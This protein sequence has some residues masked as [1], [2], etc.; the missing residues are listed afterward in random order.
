MAQQLDNSL[1][2]F[3]P[4]QIRPGALLIS[5]GTGV[6]L[7][8]GMALSLAS[9]AMV[10]AAII[11]ASLIGLAALAYVSNRENRRLR[12]HQAAS[13][14]EW[15]SAS[16]E[17]QRQ[18]LNV[19][20]GELSRALKSE[21]NSISDLRTAFI[22]A[23]DLALRQIEQEECVPLK[24]NVVAGGVPFDAA[25]VKDNVLICGEFSFLVSPEL[26]Q[27]RVVAMMK[28]IAAVNRSL[29][30]M[31][32]GVRARLMVVIVTQMPD[33][34]MAA[35]RESLSTA[36]FSSTPTDIDIRLLDFDSLQRTYISE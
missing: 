17:L 30:V 18:N 11:G 14:I 20:V 10:I 3:A 23:E 26:P 29:Q 36:R 25:F 35:L 27:E 19:A 8:A 15:G 16:P 6:L 32:V 2:R 1:D 28:K 21:P 5:G 7:I 33:T 13:W 22:V 31:N 9:G 12:G 4:G 24:R 34:A